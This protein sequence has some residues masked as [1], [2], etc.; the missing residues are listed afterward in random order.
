MAYR[1]MP[2]P[3][4]LIDL[5]GRSGH[6]KCDFADSSGAVDKISTDSASRVPSVIAELLVNFYN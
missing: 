6:F 4:T 1:I 2:F 5:Q 3:M